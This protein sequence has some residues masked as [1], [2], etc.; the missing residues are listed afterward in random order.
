MDLE[1]LE[2]L[3][4]LIWQLLCHNKS[5]VCA[6]AKLTAKIVCTLFC[7][8]CICTWMSYRLIVA[9]S[10]QLFMC[11]W[12]EIKIGADQKFWVFAW[13]QIVAQNLNPITTFSL[14]HVASFPGSPEKWKIDFSFFLG[15]WK[16][17]YVTCTLNRLITAFN[18]N[19]L[20]T[21]HGPFSQILSHNNYG[22]AGLNAAL[23]A[24]I[25]LLSSFYML[26]SVLCMMCVL[27]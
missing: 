16:R 3:D 5:P 6:S 11:L 21:V 23:V 10:P 13:Y 27:L 15:A 14:W 26:L 24:A 18:I 2:Y 22:Y 7:W 19:F 17:G 9:V 8:S 25:M 4:W 20:R 12:Q 1:P